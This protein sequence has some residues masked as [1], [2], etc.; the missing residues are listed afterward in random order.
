MLAKVV[1]RGFSDD[2][3]TSYRIFLGGSLLA[4]LELPVLLVAG[5]LSYG[6]CKVS[7]SFIADMA[8]NHCLPKTNAPPNRHMRSLTKVLLTRESIRL[9]SHTIHYQNFSHRA[10]E[11]PI[12][13]PEMQSMTHER[14][15]YTGAL[16]MMPMDFSKSFQPVV[17]RTHDVI[18][19]RLYW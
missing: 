1:R 5:D 12:Q 7:V 14:R 2:D 19:L 18:S 16:L 17:E 11:G 8:G 9:V 4:T 15:H 6:K 3:I 10:S 13:S